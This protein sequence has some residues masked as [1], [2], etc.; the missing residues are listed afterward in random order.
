MTTHWATPDGWTVD[1]I[2]LSN[3]PNPTR[4]GDP[5][6]HYG[7][8][9]YLHVTHLGSSYA[10][11]PSIAELAELAE[12]EC[13]DHT[14]L[15]DQPTHVVVDSRDGLVTSTGPDGEPFGRDDAAAHATARNAEMA[16]GSEHTHRVYA[17]VEI[18]PHLGQ[19]GAN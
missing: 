17:L 1:V 19:G 3:T 11:C 2:T 9:Q 8:R 5:A 10:Y 18:D 16:K 7:P 6:K 14:R 4:P 13:W 12:R 15:V